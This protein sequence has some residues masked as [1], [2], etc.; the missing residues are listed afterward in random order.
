MG[1]WYKTCGVSGLHIVDGEEVMV[2]ALEKNTDQTERCYSTAFWAPAM[3]PFYA[4][5]ADYGGGCDETGPALPFLLSGI[6]EVMIEQELGENEYH[7]IAVKR[8]DFDIELFYE[9]VH[10]NRLFSKDYQGREMMI[11]FVMVRKD[12]AD[13]ILENFQREEY[14]GEGGDCGWNNHYKMVTFAKILEDLPEYI[15][16]FTKSLKVGDVKEDNELQ[17]ALTDIKFMRGMKVMGHKSTNLVNRWVSGDDY[18]YSSLV[19]PQEALIELFTAGKIEEA[20]EL[21]I[22]HLKA[23]YIDCFMEMTRKNWG[24]G[25]HEGSQANEHHGYRVLAEATLR[26]L[27]RESAE[28]EEYNDEEVLE[29]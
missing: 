10:E 21:L 9:A 5:Y 25:G 18:R 23:R 20:T 16:E 22:D 12:I 17:K 24:P 3:L 11:D 14:V 28:N 13:D 26:A 7:D 8:A 6:K 2:F 19:R 15:A 29:D 27:D 1:S 4:K